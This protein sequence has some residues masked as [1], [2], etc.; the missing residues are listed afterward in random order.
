M[1]TRATRLNNLW[2]ED[3]TVVVLTFLTT[4]LAFDYS[5]RTKKYHGKSFA[6]VHSIFTYM[7]RIS[8]SN[9]KREIRIGHQ[10]KRFQTSY[11]VTL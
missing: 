11:K 9:K 5:N 10:N 4:L 6:S 1:I 3:G 8:K 7:A 2:S